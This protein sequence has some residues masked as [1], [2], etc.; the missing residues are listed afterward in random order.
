VKSEKR[1]VLK[2]GMFSAG[3]KGGD[4][5]GGKIEGRRIYS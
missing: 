2:I 5:R 3:E 1:R 4:R